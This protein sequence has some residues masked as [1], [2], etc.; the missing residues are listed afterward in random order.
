VQ[1]AVARSPDEA[2]ELAALPIEE[3]MSRVHEREIEAV[4]E[5]Y[6]AALATECKA[7]GFNALPGVAQLLPALAARGDV[8]LGLC[9]GNL[10]RGAELKLGATGLWQHFSFGGYGSDAEPRPLIV[11]KA[12]ERAQARGAT[13]ALVIDDTPRGILAAHANG[14]PACGVATGRFSAHDLGVHGAEMVVESF[15]DVARSLALLCGPI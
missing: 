2:R 6:L 8:L 12:W 4:L 3:R 13:E 7:G 5:G 15:A 10:E 1:S 9:T 14:L 11:K